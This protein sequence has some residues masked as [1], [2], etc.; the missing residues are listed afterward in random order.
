MTV[1]HE[2]SQQPNSENCTFQLILTGFFCTSPDTLSQMYYMH[3]LSC[4]NLG[5]H[6]ADNN[7]GFMFV[8][9]EEQLAEV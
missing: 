9:Q 6:M 3:Q 2:K 1:E 4:Y 7:Q 5:V 8:W